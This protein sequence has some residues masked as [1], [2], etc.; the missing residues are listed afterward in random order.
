MIYDCVDIKRII[1]E[2]DEFENGERKLLNFGHTLA[3]A[4]EKYYNFSG[5]SHG[6]AVAIGMVMITRASEKNG[7]SEHGLCDKIISVCEKI[8]LP[9]ECDADMKTLLK[10]CLS[11]KKAHGNSIDLCI[12][13]EIG[14]AFIYTLNT[15]K[16]EEF[17]GL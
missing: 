10:I 8:G 7:L 6:E 13:K 15:N 12:A 2:N 3:H 14:S 16:L 5:Y 1:V 9:T 17:F 4:I 11:D